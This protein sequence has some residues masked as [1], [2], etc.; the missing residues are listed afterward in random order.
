M[1]L[2]WE[3]KDLHTT[4]VINVLHNCAQLNIDFQKYAS[5]LLENNS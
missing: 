5:R 2:T 1:R 3:A 4:I